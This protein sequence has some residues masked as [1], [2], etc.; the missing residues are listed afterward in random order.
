MISMR[1][2]PK[3]LLATT[4]GNIKPPATGR[5]EH[6][7]S[8]VKGLELRISCTGARSW[9]LLYKF[10]GVNRRY[11]L[12]ANPKDVTAARK[13]ADQALAQVRAG[14]DPGVEKKAKRQAARG[15]QEEK[16]AAKL[17][18]KLSP[19]P[20]HEEGSVNAIAVEYLAALAQTARPKTIYEAK[21]ALDRHILPSLGTRQMS[22]ITGDDIAPIVRRLRARGKNVSANRLIAR[23]SA[24]W[25]WAL[26]PDVRALKGGV[27]PVEGWEQTEERERTRVLDDAEIALFWR[28]TE[29]LGLFKAPMRMLLLTGQRRTEVAAMTWAEVNAGGDVWT[30]PEARAK[31]HRS[32]DV[33]L[34]DLAREQLPARTGE[35]VF[36]TRQK[37]APLTAWSWAQEKLIATMNE[38]RGDD[39]LQ[40]D[41]PPFVLHDLRRTV[42][43]GMAKLRIRQEAVERLL[44][45]R[46]G[47]VSGIAAVYNQFTYEDE[48]ADAVQAWSRKIQSLIDPA[49]SN[50]TPLHA[51]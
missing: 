51:A 21:R 44:N 2:E 50:V 42:S 9:S 48:V 20:Q 31:N 45:H 28:A 32:N 1:H 26:R 43:T 7:D 5:D 38:L 16:R 36:K 6:P 47:R 15:E 13:E 10:N 49:P 11:T 30:I 25:N 33:P 23:I 29:K 12:K 35:Y 41:V 14:I 37:D 34:S 18:R 4:I 39:G 3:K 19:T 24:F 40:G 22:T 46:S 27:S 8:V 17:R